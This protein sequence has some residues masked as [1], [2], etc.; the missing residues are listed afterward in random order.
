MKPRYGFIVAAI[1]VAAVLVAGCSG[2]TPTAPQSPEPPV[3]TVAN[4]QIREISRTID[5]IG[6]TEAVKMVD[7]IPEVSGSIVKIGFKDGQMVNVGD[8]LYEIDPIPFKAM[9]DKA[10]ADVANAKAQLALAEA[11]LARVRQAAASG[12]ISK[13]EID[14]VVAKRDSAQAM[15][16]ASEAEVIRTSFNLSRTK[17]KSPIAGRIERTLM[18]EGNLVTANSSRLTRIVT[19]HPM[20]AYYDVDEMTSLR[21]RSMIIKDKTLSD[22]K[23]STALKAWIKL[24]N[25]DRYTREGTVDYI[26]AEVNRASATRTI[27]SVFPNEDG[28]ITP[29]ESVRIRLEAGAKRQVILIPEIAIGSQ[30]GQKYVYTINDKNEAMMTIV[31]LGEVRDGFQVVE[32]GLSATDRIVVNGLLRVRPGVVV[33]PVDAEA[34]SNEKKK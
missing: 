32:K 24:K 33:K 29:G 21:Y 26:E 20:Y 12:S 8:L 23:E 13:I 16:Q 15:L 19:I 31:T 1:L 11:D 17:I 6:R 18:T 34:T 2:P 27:R 30:Q 25:E 28:F 22:P 3:V 14:Q 7:I 9:A 10:S 5:L 4:P